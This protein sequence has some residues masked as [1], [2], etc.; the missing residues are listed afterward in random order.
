[1]RKVLIVDDE[2]NIRFSFGS[3]LTDEGFDVIE[4][5]NLKEA[6]DII[7]TTK[8][9]VAI[10]DRL[11]GSDDGM[12]LIE[13]IN[14]AQSNCSAILISAFPTFKS[15]SEGINH[16]IFAYLQKP[17][18]KA[19]L[20]KIV[21]AA[22][23]NTKDK[24]QALSLEQQLMQAQKM[25]TIGMISSG[26]IHDFNNLLMVI[27]GYIDLS[28]FDLPENSPLLE[29]LKKIQK[30]NQ[31]GQSIS[32]KFLSFIKQENQKPVPVQSQ[33]LVKKVLALLRIMVPKT[34]CIK[35][36]IGDENDIVLVYPSQI[37]QSIINIGMNAMHAMED[38]IGTI[39][40]TLEPTILNANSMNSPDKDQSRYIKISIMDTGCGMNEDTL[41]QIFD[42][43]FSTRP[44]GVGTG[45]GLS[46]T[47]KIIKNH[48]GEMTAFS[49]LGKGSTFHVFLPIIEKSTRVNV[50]KKH[51]IKTNIIKFKH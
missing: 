42:P 8:L 39:E 37:E 4:A 35:D 47:Q 30:V 27:S 18:R 48:G 15:A 25:E 32:K 34:I 49:Q 23:Q 33:S 9:D 1:M 14:K 7:D 40:V 13:H 31:H 45:L 28:V 26:I 22:T 29:N 21:A 41:N 10:V 36:N 19:E 11:L 50:L 44:K 2:E 46:T 51:L 6:K 43:F 38:E 17:I 24:Q 20:C 12:A 3:I 5:A 16:N